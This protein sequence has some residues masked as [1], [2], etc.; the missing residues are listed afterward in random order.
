MHVFHLNQ[1]QNLNCSLDPC[2]SLKV[3][4]KIL[5][6]IFM[7]VFQLDKI[8]N[9]LFFARMYFTLSNKEN[10][11]CFFHACILLR[12]KLKIILINFS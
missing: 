7:H 8:K 6:V 10:F 3:I 11:K 1:K 2:A 9:K 4:K 5:N 12:Q